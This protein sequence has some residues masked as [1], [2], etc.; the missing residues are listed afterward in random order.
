[1]REAMMKTRI[2]E[3]L[4]ITFPIIQGGMQYVSYPELAAAVSNS[5]GMGTINAT[6]YSSG[7][8]F[9]EMSF[10]IIFISALW[11]R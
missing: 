3:M 8:E 11:K 10:D 2:T 5:G 4:G 7:E 6:L 1:M 9:K